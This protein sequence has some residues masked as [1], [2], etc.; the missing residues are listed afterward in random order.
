MYNTFSTTLPSPINTHSPRR[1]CKTLK[2]CLY[3]L[4]LLLAFSIIALYAS[5]T[6][7]GLRAL[8]PPY[9]TPRK[10]W[11]GLR[12]QTWAISMDLSAGYATASIAFNNGTVLPI[13]HFTNDPYGRYNH[14]ISHMS[15]EESVHPTPP[16]YNRTA[17]WRDLGR[18]WK[19]WWDKKRGIP[20]SLDVLGL[21]S[22]MLRLETEGNEWLRER[23]LDY[24]QVVFVTVPP[25]LAL[26]NEDLVDAA[27]FRGLTLLTLPW[28]VHRSG[29][30]AQWPVSEINT[31]MAGLGLGLEGVFDTGREEHR[32]MRLEDVIDE[33]ESWNENVFSVLFTNDVLT[34]HVSPVSFAPHFYAAGG[35]VDFTLGS[36]ERTPYN[37]DRYW[38]DVRLALSKALD[39]YLN[40]G[41]ELGRVIVHGNQVENEEFVKILREEVEAAQWSDEDE[42]R[43][44]WYT[45][46]E[47]TASRGAAIFGNWCH[48][49]LSRGDESGCFPDLT[50]RGPGW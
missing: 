36:K 23:G 13:A 11:S 31:A 30:A 29:D 7:V 28:Y 8:S 42:K 48:R 47:Y 25:L 33:E 44:R 41:H 2:E 15:R 18:Q 12:N 39:S 37:E 35:I 3:F 32:E 38:Q 45:G 20:A 21:I 9:P 49:G 19:R 22:A 6:A 17:Q 34:A 40:R 24:M 5:I 14:S 10:D 26:Y 16:Y 4:V 1:R 46:D 43:P 27:E 50:P